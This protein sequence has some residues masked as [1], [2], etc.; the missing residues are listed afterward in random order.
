MRFVASSGQGGGGYTR[1][2]ELRTT[3]HRLPIHF[4]VPSTM[5]KW[6]E[7]ERP[8]LP[9][10]HRLGSGYI[11]CPPLLPGLWRPDWMSHFPQ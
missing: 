9:D 7:S 6:N 2:R 3:R 10:A 4:P 8:S 11:A 1:F 5:A